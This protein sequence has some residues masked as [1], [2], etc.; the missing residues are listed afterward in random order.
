VLIPTTGADQ[1]FDV[2]NSA[3]AALLNHLFSDPE[4]MGESARM[5]AQTAQPDYVVLVEKK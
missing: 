5:A 4:A 1:T 2:Y 3:T